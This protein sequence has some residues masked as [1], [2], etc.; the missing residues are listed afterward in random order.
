MPLLEEAGIAA[1]YF[2]PPVATAVRGQQVLHLA[3]GMAA[4]A[5]AARAYSAAAGLARV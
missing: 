2:C 3:D 4:N 1:P 5:A